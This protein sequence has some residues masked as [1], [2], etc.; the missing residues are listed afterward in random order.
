MWGKSIY[1]KWNDW[2]VFGWTWLMLAKSKLLLLLSQKKDFVWF[3]FQHA[4]TTKLIVHFFQ[5]SACSNVFSNQT[6]AIE[7]WVNEQSSHS[8]WHDRF[9][10]KCMLFFLPLL[11]FP[12]PEFYETRHDHEHPYPVCHRVHITSDWRKVAGCLLIMELACNAKPKNWSC[13][14]M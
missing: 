11:H 2:L 5:N 14:R 12:I 9:R 7:K 8:P 3:F 10:K 6:S 4:W 1:Q 13:N